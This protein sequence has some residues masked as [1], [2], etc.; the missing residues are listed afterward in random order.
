MPLEAPETGFVWLHVPRREPV[1]VV[2]VSDIATWWAHFVRV[3]GLKAARAARCLK[4]DGLECS[5][6]AQEVGRRAR[7]VFAVR[8]GEAVRLVE[9]G[10]VQYPTLSMIYD[11]GRWLGSR[12][13]LAREWDAANARIAVSFL[14]REAISPEVEVQVGEYVAGL[15]Q[16]EARAFKVPAVRVEVPPSKGSLP[17]SAN[18]AVPVNRWR[19]RE[20]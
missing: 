11:G 16:A 15:G 14:G 6:C 4:A 20:P 8:T 7:Y 1:D 17:Q 9:L 13:R 5:F 3:P 12:L 18:G 2:V 19:D 10:R